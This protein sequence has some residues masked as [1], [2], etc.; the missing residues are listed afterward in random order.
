MNV[1]KLVVLSFMICA[2]LVLYGVENMIPA[3]MPVPGVKL[4]LANTVTPVVM[5]LYGRKE[6]FAVLILRIFIAAL[7][8][9]QA[10]SLAFSLSGGVMCLLACSVAKGAFD[11]SQ[12]WAMGIIGA[13][14]HNAGQI[15]AAIILTGQTAIA[16][17]FLVLL[18]AGMITGALTG[19]CAS[20]CV[21]LIRK[22]KFI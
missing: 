13:V 17:Y 9:G 14:A 10:V 1:R 19:M 11:E 7:L 4:G 5:Y 22:H 21:R 12:L 3:I 2:A 20:Y 16:Y 18:I 15:G 8:F 6:A